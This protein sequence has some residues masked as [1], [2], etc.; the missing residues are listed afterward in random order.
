VCVAAEVY[1]VWSR[2]CYGRMCY[3]VVTAH[4]AV[5]VVAEV[6]GV[7]SRRCYGRMLIQTLLKAISLL[8]R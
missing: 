8:L 3:N 4:I 1:G 5:C 7:W 6:Y 2:R